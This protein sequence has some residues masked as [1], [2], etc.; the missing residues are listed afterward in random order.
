VLVNISRAPIVDSG[1]LYSALAEERIGGA[2]LDVWYRY[3][4]GAEADAGTEVPP[5]DR[6][7]WDLPNA[8]CTPHSSAWTSRLPRRRYAVIADNVNR[9]ASGRPLRNLVRAGAP[10]AT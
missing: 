5:A 4:T 1:A 10:V 8:W 6:P 9:L 7:F 2:I 3:P